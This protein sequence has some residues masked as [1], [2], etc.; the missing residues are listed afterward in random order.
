MN[1]WCIYCLTRAWGIL[2]L[3]KATYQNPWWVESKRLHWVSE[4]EAET[5][6]Q[7]TAGCHCASSEGLVQCR[8]LICFERKKVAL[9]FKH[10]SGKLPV[11]WGPQTEN[12]LHYEYF[13]SV[14]PF[15]CWTSISSIKFIV[16]RDLSKKTCEDNYQNIFF[17]EQHMFKALIDSAT[18][19]GYYKAMPYSC[20]DA[21]ES[22]I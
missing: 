19:T 20:A 1:H 17:K 6:V 18:L 3:L 10:T 7:I 9:N 13:M 8:S 21:Y 15:F 11:F 12:L 2:A 5:L 22:P 4:S 16:W 14:L